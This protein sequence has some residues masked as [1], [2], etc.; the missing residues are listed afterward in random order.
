[1][2]D[3]KIAIHLVSQYNEGSE[4]VGDSADAKSIGEQIGINWDEVEFTPEDLQAGIEVELEHGSKDPDTDVTGDDPLLT[5]KIAWAHLK[6]S[7]IYYDLLS[8]M[9]EDF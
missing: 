2:N 9:E 7:P 6:E 8:K 1:M 4:D 5:A 3:L